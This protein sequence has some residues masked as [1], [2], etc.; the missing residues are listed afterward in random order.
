[1]SAPGTELSFRY[2]E[3]AQRHRPSDQ[4]AL[5]GEIRRLHSLCLRPR[6][7]ASALRLDLRIVL[8]AIAG[9]P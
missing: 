9:S 3:R 6:D 7:I 8:D 5:A 4:A 2:E 1:M